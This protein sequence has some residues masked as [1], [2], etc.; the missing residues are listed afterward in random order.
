[1]ALY[2]GINKIKIQSTQYAGLGFAN[3]NPAGVACWRVI[4]MHDEGRTAPV[5][6][7]YKSK[8]ELL[9]DLPRYAAIWG[10]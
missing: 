9:Q 2:N 7:I 6:P 4:D 10:Y 5:G 3:T 1:M 8:F